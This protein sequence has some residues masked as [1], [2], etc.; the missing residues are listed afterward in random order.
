VFASN[1]F[2]YREWRQ[3]RRVVGGALT[4]WQT[5]SDRLRL[6]LQAGIKLPRGLRRQRN[7]RQRTIRERR[8]R[9]LSVYSGGI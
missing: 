2:P 6:V 8:F 9:D 7:M 4:E 3:R 1:R 5:I